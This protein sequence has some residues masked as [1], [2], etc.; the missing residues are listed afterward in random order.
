MATRASSIRNVS[1][2]GWQFR[3]CRQSD[4][5]ATARLRSVAQ[6]SIF[7]KNVILEFADSLS[8]L[9]QRA[10]VQLHRAAFSESGISMPCRKT[11]NSYGFLA[12]RIG[13]ACVQSRRACVQ[14]HRAIFLLNT[15][16]ECAHSLSD[17][18]SALAFSCAGHDWPECH[19]AISNTFGASVSP[20]P[21]VHRR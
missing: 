11:K 20:A 2:G 14:S 12:V 1:V 7:K 16:V 17:L 10:C 8:D 21:C 18:D 4:G 6:G 9:K 3:V 19:Q 13:R 15:H 5:F